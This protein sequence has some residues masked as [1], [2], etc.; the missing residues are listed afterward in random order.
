M[1]SLCHIIPCET[2]GQIC[3][4]KFHKTV[5]GEQISRTQPKGLKATTFI[6]LMK[7][8]NAGEERQHCSV[9]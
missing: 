1:S 5:H 2:A 9:N 6:V 3:V 8:V 4:M 7:E